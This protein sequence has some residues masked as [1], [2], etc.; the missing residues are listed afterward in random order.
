MITVGSFAICK[1]DYISLGTSALEWMKIA[2]RG[3][4]KIFVTTISVLFNSVRHYFS[5][6]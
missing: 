5:E 1:C 4:Y 6:K 2:N 3:N